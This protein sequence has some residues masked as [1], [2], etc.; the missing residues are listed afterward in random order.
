MFYGIFWSTTLFLWAWNVFYLN[1]NGLIHLIIKIFHIQ[2]KTDQ[3]FVVMGN[4]I[5]YPKPIGFGHARKPLLQLPL[6]GYC[7]NSSNRYN[8]S[9]SEQTCSTLI[10]TNFVPILYFFIIIL[11]YFRT[12][13]IVLRKQS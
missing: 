9:C 4:D 6:T 1:L 3:H 12:I 8:N 5:L 13:L 7:V 10:P 11:V 2:H